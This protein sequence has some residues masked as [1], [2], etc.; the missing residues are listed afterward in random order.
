MEIGLALSGG[1]VLGAAHIG[2]LEELEKA[3][4]PLARVAGTS[5]G[6]IM[7]SLFCAGGTAAVNAFV[8]EVSATFSA[9]R[10]Y[11]VNNTP[12]K[13]FSF[14]GEELTKYL[15]KDF[16]ELPHPFSVVATD[17]SSG[18]R[19]VF[20]EGNLPAAVLASAAYPGVFPLQEIDGRYYVDGG[21]T[22]NLPAD[23]VRE[24]GSEFVIGSSIYA[25][26][27]IAPEEAAT[28]NWVKVGVRGLDIMQA[29]LAE[30][31][32]DGCDFC[33]APTLLQ[34]FRWYYFGSIA[35]IR[36]QGR[37]YARERIDD[38]LAALATV[39]SSKTS[40]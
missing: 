37:R 31:Q 38:L 7:G 5:A 25:V 11:I 1:G 16:A 12:Q 39:R 3:Q 32:V 26:P 40:E 9:P 21:L 19:K 29:R 23:I 13:I 2:M 28:L 33:F 8:D 30:E 14:I 24:Q 35:E 18:T 10:G 22:G 17:L 20:G 27:E 36:E 34:E 6:A 4:I 15:P